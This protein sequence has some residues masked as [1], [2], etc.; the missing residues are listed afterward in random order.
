ME[1]LW[2]DKLVF[3]FFACKGG[4]VT[5]SRG[6]KLPLIISSIS[7]CTSQ[8]F[9]AAENCLTVGLFLYLSIYLTFPKTVQCNFDSVYASLKW[10]VLN[11]YMQLSFHIGSENSVHKKRHPRKPVLRIDFRISNPSGKLSDLL[12]I[13]A[14]TMLYFTWIFLLSWRFVTIC[15]RFPLFFFFFGQKVLYIY[16]NEVNS[17]FTA[18][19]FS[20]L[21]L[22]T[23]HQWIRYWFNE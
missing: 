4:I 15:L 23:K 10:Q 2:L 13:S 20:N 1:V 19:K 22:Q 14:F 18:L 16:H 8:F 12:H 7:L 17:C 6:K 11:H 5:D 3:F 9:E 21:F